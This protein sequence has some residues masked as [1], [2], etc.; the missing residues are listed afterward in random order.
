[1]N[2]NDGFATLNFCSLRRAILKKF[3]GAELDFGGKQLSKLLKLK[4]GLIYIGG[5]LVRIL[6]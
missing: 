4:K 2:K 6:I 5:P 3:D 1:M